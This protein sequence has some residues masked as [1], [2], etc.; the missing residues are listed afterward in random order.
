MEAKKLRR[1]P[2]AVG[3]ILDEDGNTVAQTFSQ[4]A[5]V[6]YANDE[7]LLRPLSRKSRTW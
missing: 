1:C 4:I 7:A 3:A 6:Q 2:L 5:G